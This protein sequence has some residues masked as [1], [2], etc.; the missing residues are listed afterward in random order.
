MNLRKGFV[1]DIHPEDNSVDL[2]MCDDG[3]RL[4]GVQVLSHIGSA[5]TGLVDLTEVPNVKDG[6]DKWDI[7]E[8]N[9]QD[10]EAY[11]ASVSGG[12][13]VVGFSLPQISQM[14]FDDRRRAFYRHQSDVCHTIDGEGNLEIF[15]PSGSYVRL[16]QD[17]RHDN[18]EGKNFDE[19]LKLD[20]NTDKPV[21]FYVQ[22]SAVDGSVARA[23]AEIAPDGSI[24]LVSVDGLGA[25]QA[26]LKML[27][28]GTIEVFSQVSIDLKT[29]LVT[30]TG[31]MKVQ[32]D[33]VAGPVSLRNHVHTEVRSGDD[34]SGP[35]DGG[36]FSIPGPASA[37]SGAGGSAG[38]S[39]GGTTSD[40]SFGG[41]AASG[42]D[43]G[44][45]GWYDEAN[46]YIWF[47]YYGFMPDGSPGWQNGHVD[48]TTRLI[49]YAD[50]SGGSF[51]NSQFM[52]DQWLWQAINQAP[53]P[54]LNPKGIS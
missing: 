44:Q 52:V 13:V 36:G 11:V 16:A 10:M 29:P 30:L 49:W 38:G 3:S 27:A 9:G 34:L 7:T 2:F 6:D 28:D 8:R 31:S 1:V 17:T 14:T 47:S 42:G 19:N 39:S 45:Y 32:G 54:L 21:S 48:C 20:R 15:H 46:N 22:S 33:V 51:V 5:R 35:P 12:W 37:R 23:T 41:G 4:V 26:R 50:G 40:G 18:L 53:S 43:Y 24:T 25:P